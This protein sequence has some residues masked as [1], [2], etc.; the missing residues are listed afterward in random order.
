MNINDLRDEINEIDKNM[1]SLF[2]K[3]MEISSKIAQEKKILKL[4]IHNPDREEE[5]MKKNINYLSDS[6]LI[7]YYKKFQENIFSLSKDYQ[8]SKLEKTDF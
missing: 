1:A 3:R 4:P 7:P 6:S 5:L 2:E 8:K